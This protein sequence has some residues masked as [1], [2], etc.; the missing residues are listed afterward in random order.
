[1]N[2]T[3]APTEPFSIEK[4]SG[5]NQ[6]GVIGKK[7]SSPIKVLV[8]D[9]AG[10]PFVGAKVNFIANNGGSVSQAQ[11]TTGSDGTASVE[12]VS[13]NIDAIQ[14][15]KVTAFKSDNTTALLG[16]PLIFTS[17]NVGPFSIE[18]ISGDNQTGELGTKLSNPIKVRVKDDAGNPFVGA[19]VN[20]TAN[21][22]G[23]VSQAQ[24][25]TGADGTASVEWTL[26][27]IDATQTVNVTAYKSDNTT[28]LQGSPLTFS[29]CICNLKYGSFTDSRDGHVYKTI[30]IGTQ[31]WMA[32]N[33]AYLPVGA[34][35][36]TVG[37][38]VSGNDSKPFYYITD[39]TKYGVLYNWNASQSA[40]PTGWHL[41][42]DTEWTILTTF[43]G[44]ESIAG[45]KMKSTFGWSY[46][47]PTVTNSSCFSGLPG[48]MR[49][50]LGKIENQGDYGYWWSATASGS[51]YVFI[52]RLGYNDNYIN[53]DFKSHDDGYSIRCVKN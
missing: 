53:R 16:S 9:E 6:T 20:F 18:K 21:N 27:S 26:G 46:S 1:M 38:E 51:S 19:K 37:S 35:S 13:G 12:W 30:T 42:T 15:V 36:T 14:T 50:Y 44:G 2:A 10:N 39:L 31:T 3:V 28:A 49:T 17:V 4:V 33:L 8:K 11:A 34:S 48:G 23:S 40:A 47:K 25:T 24:A 29:Y 5:D 32:E 22:G 52:R 43:L 41:P 7:Q 45:D